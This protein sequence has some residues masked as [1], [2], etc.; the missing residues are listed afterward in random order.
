MIVLDFSLNTRFSYKNIE[1]QNGP[2]VKNHA[3]E[4]MLK[5][6]PEN[7]VKAAVALKQAKRGYFGWGLRESSKPLAYY[8][9]IFLTISIPQRP[10]YSIKKIRLSSIWISLSS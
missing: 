7:Y 4:W 8:G 6:K 5:K 2:K 9:S 1:A 10:G 3:W